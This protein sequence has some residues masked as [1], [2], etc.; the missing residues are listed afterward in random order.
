MY[1]KGE[2]VTRYTLYEARITEEPAVIQRSSQPFIE[3]ATVI[4]K[5]ERE[6][7]TKE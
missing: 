4:R 1:C 7:L 6:L 3:S 2:R 5:G